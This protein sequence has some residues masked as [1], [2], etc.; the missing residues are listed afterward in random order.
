MR[1]QSMIIL[2]AVILVM[3]AVIG[4]AK[5]INYT[6]TTI[7]D[8]A[9]EVGSRA[10]Q[11]TF[12]D[13]YRSPLLDMEIKITTYVGNTCR[14]QGQFEEQSAP[15]VLQAWDFES[16]GIIDQTGAMISDYG[17]HIYQKTGKYTATYYAIDLNG[18][19]SSAEIPIEVVSGTGQTTISPHK[20]KLSFTGIKEREA[21]AK[22][23]LSDPEETYA[24]LLCDP[25]D[26]LFWET[27]AKAHRGMIDS[28][29]LEDSNIVLVSIRD[30]SIVDFQYTVNGLDSAFNFLLAHMTDNDDL[31]ILGCGHGTGRWDSSCVVFGDYLYHDLSAVPFSNKNMSPVFTEDERPGDG[32]IFDIESNYKI[33]W[34]NNIGYRI[35]PVGLDEWAGR[36]KNDGH[37]SRAKYVAR[38]DGLHFILGEPKTS[39]TDIYLEQIVQYLKADTNHDGYLDLN[40]GDWD[41]DGDSIP[42][43]D[44][45]QS[46][47]IYDEDDWG[48]LRLWTDYEP[49][50]SLIA[51]LY[52]VKFDSAF[53]GTVDFCWNCQQGEWTAP[54][55]HGTDS[56]N[57]GMLVGIDVDRDGNMTDSIGY[58]ES[59]Y[60]LLDDQMDDFLD[61]L[62]FRFVTFINDYCFG[63]GFINDMS[64]DSVV[65]VTGTT[66]GTVSSVF[67]TSGAVKEFPGYRNNHED[68]Q[69]TFSEY[70]NGI[71]LNRSLLDDNG[72]RVGHHPQVPNGGDGYLADSVSW[73]RL[74]DPVP[75]PILVS[76]INSDT[77]LSSTAPTLIWS[78]TGECDSFF[79]DMLVRIAYSNIYA[80]S[81]AITTDTT[82]TMKW[83]DD[84]QSVPLLYYWQVYAYRGCCMTKSA[85]GTFYFDFDSC[86]GGDGLRGDVDQ[87][88]YISLSDYLRLWNFVDSAGDH[89]PLDCL[90]EGDVVYSPDSTNHMPDAEDLEYL[91]H[92]L[93]ESGPAPDSCNP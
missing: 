38:F 43:I 20:V 53:D 84:I 19:Y 7:R 41:W 28:L 61:S 49:D 48:D 87:N 17:K 51:S 6:R 31:H 5:P 72:D 32:D 74:C 25:H 21:R 8:I 33:V 56:D 26:D 1:K 10:I 81:Y 36:W 89:Y 62:N 55:I 90:W 80:H 57:D 76:P 77:V 37:C 82:Y 47:Y 40:E 44:T 83:Y 13:E 42:P 27:I 60:L 39:D 63:G 23:S 54:P 11:D 59:A 15:V 86:C 73:G 22:S 16:D 3:I 91:H 35:S 24:L 4:F 70:F 29:G 67:M 65:I 92:Y 71:N 93:W 79:I 34:N 85:Y 78:D 75:A 30:T 88:G 14:I 9:K 68:R 45:T 46:G 18:R 64:R 69:T 52:L 58:N 2:S 12:S 66:E 50:D